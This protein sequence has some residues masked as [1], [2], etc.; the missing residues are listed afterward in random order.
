MF[1]NLVVSS[2]IIMMHLLHPFYVS[3][4]EITHNPKSRSVEISVRIFTSDLEQVLKTKT[5][6]KVD[7]LNGNETRNSQ[8]IREYIAGNIVISIDNV[9]RTLHYVGF[10][11]QGESIWAYFEIT[12]VPIM[13]RLDV[14]NSILYDFIEQQMNLVQAKAADK[15][16]MKKLNYPARTIVFYF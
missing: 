13:K 3:F 14:E 1:L 4:T 15:V 8:L 2:A 9:R 7:L 5:K 12:D 11:Q 10:E 6:E 16:E